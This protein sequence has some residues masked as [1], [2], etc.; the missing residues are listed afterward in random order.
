MTIGKRS[1]ALWDK[2][3]LTRTIRGSIM[4]PKNMGARPAFT[5]SV[6]SDLPVGLGEHRRHIISSSTLGKAIEEGYEDLKAVGGDTLGSIKHLDYYPRAY[7]TNH[8]VCRP[9]DNMDN[10][11]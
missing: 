5:T 10:H 11:A 2:G 7:G 8:R 9:T 3:V 1:Q 4:G 6:Q